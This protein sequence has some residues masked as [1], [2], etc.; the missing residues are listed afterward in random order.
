M[1]NYNL[2]SR[3]IVGFKRKPLRFFTSTFIAYAAIWT[4]LEPLISIVPPVEKYFSG[5]L[6]FFTLILVSSLIGF[7]TLRGL[8]LNFSSGWKAAE[9]P[10]YPLEKF[11]S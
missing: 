10:L 1:R 4:I 7:Y 8:N 9:L 3:I 2:V 6:K 5:E 11:K